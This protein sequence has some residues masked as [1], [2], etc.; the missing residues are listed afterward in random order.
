MAWK[1]RFK[2]PNGLLDSFLVTQEKKVIEATLEE[3]R[4][5]IYGTGDAAE[6]LGLPRTTPES[7]IR[8]LKIQQTPLPSGS[9][10]PAIQGSPRS[11]HSSRRIG[12]EVGI[13][14]R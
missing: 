13:V 8:S 3:T 1:G 5:R 11:D 7:K 12:R 2:G 9:R 10:R 14:S 6:K 4:G